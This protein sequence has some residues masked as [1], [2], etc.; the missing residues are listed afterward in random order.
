MA[1]TNETF[2]HDTILE[3]VHSH[4]GLEQMPVNLFLPLLI[5]M[6]REDL[7]RTFSLHRMQYP[8]SP[9]PV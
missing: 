1:I 6:I 9:M 4:P 5:A 3:I 2:Y 7:T 8:V